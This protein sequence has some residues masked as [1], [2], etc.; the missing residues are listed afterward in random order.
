MLEC[1]NRIEIKTWGQKR[2]APFL[3]KN[4]M[5]DFF[6]KSGN[7]FVINSILHTIE[8]MEGMNLSRSN[9]VRGK[10][11]MTLKRMQIGDHYE[12]NINVHYGLYVAS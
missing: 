12:E 10:P 11:F 6:K 8:K 2:L 7:F 9:R 3:L 4:E 5:I 1:K